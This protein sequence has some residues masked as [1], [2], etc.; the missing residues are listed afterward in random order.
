MT[1]L[2]QHGASAPNSE[3]AAEI[4]SLGP[5]FHNVHL[6]DGSQ[7]AP[8]TPLGD[9]PRNKWR[10]IA[11]HL[12]ASL[13]GWSAL[14][15]G[16][17]AGF[18]TVEL[19]RRGARVT[20]IDVEDHFLKQASWAVSQFGL[21]A[22]VEFR[23]MQVYELARSSERWDLVI[24]MGVFYHLRYPMLGLDIVAEKV[25]KMMLFQTLTSPG[26]EVAEPPAD[27]EVLDREPF[28]RRGWPKLAFIEKSLAGD[29]SNW[30]APNHA[31]VVAMLRSCGL[32]VTARPGH[33]IYLCERAP[34]AALDDPAV[35]AQLDA[36]LGRSPAQP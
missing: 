7:T 28:S 2:L 30:W 5:W 20:A 36:A 1:D 15:I 34:G 17:N 23:Q 14:D 33:E 25:G 35:R 16:C 9:F 8:G 11:P 6:P 10:R 26:Q 13:E 3:R 18:Y 31:A 27:I 4:E 22:A 29:R 19:A 32:R 12:P 24:F 21:E